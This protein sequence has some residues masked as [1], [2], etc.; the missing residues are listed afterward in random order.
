MRIGVL[1][2]TVARLPFGDVGRSFYL[3][4]MAGDQTEF[5]RRPDD[6]SIGLLVKG[7]MKRAK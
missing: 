1:L 6:P 4:K 2:R 3:E 7:T 5:G